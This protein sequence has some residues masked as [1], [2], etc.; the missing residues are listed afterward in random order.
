MNWHFGLF[1]IITTLILIL[2]IIYLLS[3]KEFF[4]SSLYIFIYCKI[5]IQ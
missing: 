4:N 5:N 3:S 2:T 1:G